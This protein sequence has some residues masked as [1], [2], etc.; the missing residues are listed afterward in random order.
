MQK[1][2]V[3]YLILCLCLATSKIMAQTVI[4]M[5]T[6]INSKKMFY[7]EGKASYYANSLHGRKTASGQKYSTKKLTAAHRTL[8]L[9]T[10][11]KVTNKK[12]G[13]WVIVTVNDRGPY[14]KK[15]ILD[16]SYRAAKHLGM[17]QGSG[18]A[19]V[20]IEELPPKD[21]PWPQKHVPDA[22]GMGLGGQVPLTEPK[23]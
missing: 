12:N 23:K 8:P 15:Y 22:P 10:R 4:P 21:Q 1:K 13:K 3:I 6:A 14:S 16:L 20:V 7:Q 18:Y 17:T 9:G 2:F 11:I 5:D 19:R